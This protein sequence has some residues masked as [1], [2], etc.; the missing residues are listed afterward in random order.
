MWRSSIWLF[1][2]ESI[3]WTIYKTQIVDVDQKAAS[4]NWNWVE[5]VC[6][7]WGGVW[8]KTITGWTPPNTNRR[9][10]RPRKKWY[11]KLDTHMRSRSITAMNAISR[12]CSAGYSAIVTAEKWNQMRLKWFLKASYLH[13]KFSC[14]ISALLFSPIKNSCFIIVNF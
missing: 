9:P 7:V 10:G 1:G 13:W 11:G 3:F 14:I 5:V 2:G 12:K 6:R 8:A 4:L